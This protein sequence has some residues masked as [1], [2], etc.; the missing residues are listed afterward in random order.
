M[1]E[2]VGYQYRTQDADWCQ[3]IVQDAWDAT[4]RQPRTQDAAGCQ[5][6]APDVLDAGDAKTPSLKSG[7]DACTS[8]AGF[9]FADALSRVKKT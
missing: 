8:D 1:L 5:K 3:G 9:I 4:G 2:A 6:C 7:R